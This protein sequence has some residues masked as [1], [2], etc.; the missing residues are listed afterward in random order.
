MYIAHVQVATSS[1]FNAAQ[2]MSSC[3]KFSL[4]VSL[5]RKWHCD[6][7]NNTVKTNFLVKIKICSINLRIVLCYNFAK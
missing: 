4:N 3:I 1:L 5:Y 2:L 7:K 6:P